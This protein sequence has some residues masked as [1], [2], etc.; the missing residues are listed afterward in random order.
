MLALAV[1]FKVAFKVG[2]NSKKDKTKA[3]LIKKT[4]K[5]HQYITNNNPVT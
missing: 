5:Y 2:N 4:K 3:T 1:S